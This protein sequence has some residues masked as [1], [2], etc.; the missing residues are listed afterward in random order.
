MFTSKMMWWSAA[1]GS[2]CLLCSFV[3]AIL[4]FGGGSRLFAVQWLSYGGCFI[5]VG[6]VGLACCL[7]AVVGI[8]V[9]VLA[10]FGS[11]GSCP[12]GA[13]VLPL[14][15]PMG[16]RVHLAGDGR[17]SGTQWTVS[18]TLDVARLM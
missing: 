5:H 8:M 7:C 10:L 11:V 1:H 6:D 4:D 2:P 14:H 15:T 17:F 9:G 13:V 16:W 3:I 12:F 18:A